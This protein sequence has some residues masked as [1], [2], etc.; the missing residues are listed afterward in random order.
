MATTK[1][2]R[3]ELQ[4]AR[5]AG[6]I[7][8]LNARFARELAEVLKLT[9]AEAKRLVRELRTKDG[10]LVATK[11][12][13]G[14]VLALRR[15]LQRVIEESGFQAFAEAASDAPLDELARLVLRGNSIAQAAASLTKP[16]LSAI[17]A[18]KTVRFDELLQVGKDAAVRLAR[19]ILDGTLG[20]QRVHDLVDDVED[21]FDVTDKQA[22]TLYDTAISIFSRQ[23]DQLHTTGEPDELFYY[24]GPLD[25][26]TRKFCRDRVGR[27]FT[28][29]ALETADNGQLPNPLLTGG[30]YNCRHQPKR[31]SKL[32]AELIELAKTGERA[33]HVQE[34]FEA[35]EQ[36]AA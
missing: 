31:V 13:L 22:R 16:D 32:D 34:I 3:L 23:V 8:E 12:N 24:A 1:A 2:E 25:T 7:D 10:R 21:V 5:E 11:A 26:K 36:E 29:T 15:D 4:A 14:R 6:L 27:V 30:G 19:I 18:F 17:A 33:A 35:L 9:N 28:R 20:L